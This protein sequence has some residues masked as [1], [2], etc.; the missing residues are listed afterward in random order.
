MSSEKVTGFYFKPS[1]RKCKESGYRCFDI[2]KN[3]GTKI[4]MKQCDV[5]SLTLINIDLAFISFEIGLENGMIH[6]WSNDN[7]KLNPLYNTF[8]VTLDKRKN[9]NNGKPDIMIPIYSRCNGKMNAIMQRQM[10][11]CYNKVYVLF[12]NNGMVDDDFEE[13]IDSVFST[14]DKAQKRLKEILLEDFG[15]LI[16]PAEG[17]EFENGL[18]YT[19][20]RIEEWKVE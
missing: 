18:T 2:Y 3:D 16:E 8:D 9:Q 20:Y 15:A 13:W 7:I 6:L 4:N 1:K 5:I 14:N 17:E 19:K 10:T 12:R 11:P